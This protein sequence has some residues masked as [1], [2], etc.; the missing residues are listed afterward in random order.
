MVEKPGECVVKHLLLELLHRISGLLIDILFDF[1]WQV[2]H[3]VIMYIGYYN[4]SFLI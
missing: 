1:S 4:A 3:V 2:E